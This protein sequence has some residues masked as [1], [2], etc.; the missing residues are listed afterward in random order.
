MHKM[1]KKSILKDPLSKNLLIDVVGDEENLPIVQALID[2]VG[3]DEKI[4][5]TTEIRLNVV[6]RVLYKLYDAQL[7]GYKRSKDPETQWFTYNWKFDEEE[8]NKQISKKAKAELANKQQKLYNEEN[9]MFF[10]CS[11]EHQRYN[12]DNASDQNFTCPDC[13][14]ELLFQDNKQKITSLKR[15]ITNFKK[16]Y[17]RAL[18]K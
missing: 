15:E 13:G 9:N 18:S 1:A 14:E 8:V 17:K 2:G 7:A 5:E 11:N 6:R 12:F 4:A 16:K 10:I 3:T